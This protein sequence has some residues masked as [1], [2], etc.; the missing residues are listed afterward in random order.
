MTVDNNSDNSSRN[1][2][3]MSKSF[4]SFS[5]YT[6]LSADFNICKLENTTA[7]Y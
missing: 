2:L 4:K 1:F 3:R 7:K 5:L 6:N